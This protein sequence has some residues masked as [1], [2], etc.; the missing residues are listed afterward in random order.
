[1]RNPIIG[2]YLGLRQFILKGPQ[3]KMFRNNPFCKTNS[4]LRLLRNYMLYALVQSEPENEYE[5]PNLRVCSGLWGRNIHLKLD[6]DMRFPKRY[7]V[8]NP[9]GSLFTSCALPAIHSTL[10]LRTRLHIQDDLL[11]IVIRKRLGR[12]V[13]LK[14]RAYSDEYII[15][16]DKKIIFS[17]GSDGISYTEDDIKFQINPE[18][19]NLNLSGQE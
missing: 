13:D 14:A 7:W 11:Q 5:D 2:E 19:L 12:P 10:E 8:Y 4:S 3:S 6:E 1:M 18:V 17:P 9:M 16:S 15:D